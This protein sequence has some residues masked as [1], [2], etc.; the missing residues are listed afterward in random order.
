MGQIEGHRWKTVRLL[1][2]LEHLPDGISKAVASGII[3]FF[4]SRKRKRRRQI[5]RLR[6]RLVSGMA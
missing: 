1:L 4:L 3:R 5:R 6:F 2:P